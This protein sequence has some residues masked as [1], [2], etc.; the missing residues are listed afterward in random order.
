MVVVSAHCRRRQYV[1][2]VPNAL[3]SSISIYSPSI[4]ILDKYPRPPFNIYTYLYINVLYCYILIYYSQ[5]EVNMQP[6]RNAK[7]QTKCVKEIKVQ[8]AER[9]K[10]LPEHLLFKSVSKTSLVVA[11]T[12]NDKTKPNYQY[13]VSTYKSNMRYIPNIQ[14]FLTLSHLPLG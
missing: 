1:H 12:L 6:K 3:P 10:V 8:V 13:P 14:S 11:C 4:S 9:W 5:F 2:S 7:H